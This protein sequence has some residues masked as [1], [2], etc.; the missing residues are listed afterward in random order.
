MPAT[1]A[2]SWVGLRKR[3]RRKGRHGGGRQAGKFLL[4]Q[5]LGV[6]IEAAGHGA[7]S[8]S[9]TPDDSRRRTAGFAVFSTII[10]AIS[11]SSA[12]AL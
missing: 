3:K 6:V 12:R 8:N 7:A 5:N 1:R 4:A 9:S 10:L 2:R 11:A